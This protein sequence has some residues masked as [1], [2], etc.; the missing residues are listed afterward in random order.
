VRVA[1][2]L[3]I[4]REQLDGAVDVFAAVLRELEQRLPAAA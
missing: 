4:T 2:P 1:P 3:T